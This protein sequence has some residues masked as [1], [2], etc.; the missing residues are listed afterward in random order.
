MNSNVQAQQS[1]HLHVTEKKCKPS[2]G[3]CVNRP[4]VRGKAVPAARAAEASLHGRGG[5][6][7][8][9]ASRMSVGLA[10]HECLVTASQLCTCEGGRHN[11]GAFLACT[12]LN[13]LRAQLAPHSLS[14][15]PHRDSHTPFA[16][17]LRGRGL[18]AG[19][20]WSRGVTCVRGMMHM[21]LGHHAPCCL[22]WVPA[23]RAAGIALGGF[24]NC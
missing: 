17:K 21:K 18:G 22:G 23:D 19:V 7:Q 12:S 20:K 6:W 14:L 5:S 15:P 4:G 11:G 24:L 3:A 16:V 1:T 9:A 10:N 8:A 13:M 2:S